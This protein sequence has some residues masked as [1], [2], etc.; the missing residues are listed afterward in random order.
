[1]TERNPGPPL[2]TRASTGTWADQ[3]LVLVLVAVGLYAATLVLAGDVVDRTLFRAL[4]FGS[5]AEVSVE[6]ADHSQLL[7]GVLGAVILGWMVLILTVVRGPLRRRDPWAWHAVV[8]SL[9][10]WFVVD[11]GFSLVV[12]EWEHAVFNLGFVVSLGIP[13]A[14][15]RASLET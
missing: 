8:L 14:S 2:E 3:M 5:E 11:T 1:M 9:G 13:L 15:I 12:G 6:T 7:R 4:G 10:I